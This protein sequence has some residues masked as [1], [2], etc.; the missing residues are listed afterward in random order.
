LED[1]MKI[2]VGL[3]PTEY[4]MRPAPLGRALEQRGFES[5]FVVEHTH[6][7][8]S[9]RTPYP[10]GGPLPSIYWES[11]EP[12]TFL[13]QVAAVTEKLQIGTGVC[14]VPE[15]HPIAL[16]KRVASLDSLSHGRFLFGIGA[17]WN[18]EELENHGVAFG[19]RWKVLRE[20]VLAM[21]AC[22][23][24]KDA[25]YQGEFV[26]FDPVWVEPKPARKPHPPILIG[27]ASKWAIERVVEF[28]DGWMPIAGAPGF[29]ERLAQLDALCAKKGRARSSIDVSVFAAP[30]A[31]DQ[32]AK[33][34]D[35]GV[36]R[37]IAILPT[38]PESDS[39]KVLDGYADLVRWGKELG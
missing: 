12:F 28:A 39:L 22:W 11:Y 13:A 7:P 5:L 24:E 10:A 4:S 38:L 21:K 35:Q 8:A 19:N 32:V 26:K 37:V 20:S 16:A 27:A 29:E 15:H 33:L 31:K 30:T 9:R 36:N 17:G 2:G 18:A 6:I 23:T 3:F 1:N 25:S 14:L 34:R